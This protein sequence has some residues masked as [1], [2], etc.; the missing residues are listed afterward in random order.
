MLKPELYRLL[1]EQLAAKRIFLINTPEEYEKYHLLPGWYDDFAG[2]TPFSVWEN[3][4]TAESAL[5]LLEG[6]EGSFVVKDFVK[7]RKHEWYDA[8]FIRDVSDRVNAERVIRNFLVRQGEDLVGGVVLRKYEP[9]CPVGFHEK[10]GMSI[11]KEYRVFILAGKMMIH[12]KYWQ[13][14]E[15]CGS[16]NGD[17]LFSEEELRWIET[18]VSKVKKLFR[19]HGSGETPGRKADHHGIR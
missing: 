3:Q 1:Y 15:D 5:R 2:D 6:C 10:S 7:S 18:I 11:S 13:E 17:T 14:A 19:D 4:G 9:L 8:C 16:E 12:G